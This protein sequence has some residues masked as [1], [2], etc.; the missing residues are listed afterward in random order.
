M[1]GDAID[2]DA[3]FEGIEELPESVDTAAI[4]RMQFVASVLDDSIRVPGT[5]YRIGLDPLIGLVPGG[6]DLL[7]GVLSLY[8]VAESARLGVSV[9]TLVHM[10]ANVALDVG[11]GSIPYFG[12]V[13]DAG[14]KANKRNVRLAMRELVTD[15]ERVAES[16]EIDVS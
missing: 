11:A 6:G 10:L 13:F 9:G 5:S 14:W 7:A 15:P 16:A 8:I 3:T 2:V 1:T 4:E 12:D